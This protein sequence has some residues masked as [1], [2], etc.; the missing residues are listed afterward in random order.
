MAPGPYRGPSRIFECI[1]IG[2]I[3]LQKS[4]QFFEIVMTK[5]CPFPQQLSQNEKV[6]NNLSN[7]SEHVTVKYF[8]FSMDFLKDL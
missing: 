7:G 5:S 6:L 8:V 1:E 3:L 2:E 4:P